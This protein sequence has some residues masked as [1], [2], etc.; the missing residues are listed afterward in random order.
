MSTVLLLARHAACAVVLTA[1]VYLAAPAAQVPASARY[2]TYDELT[3]ELRALAKSHANLVRLVDLGRSHEGRSVWAV[4]LANA[5]GSATPTDARPALFV[6][7]NFEGDQIIGSEIA[8]HLAG[9]LAT[10]YATSA[11]V[12]R[13]LDD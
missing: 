9:H 11:E 6:A 13:V 2:H 3:A 7:A 8:L 12:K 1:A 5:G 4:E 10:A